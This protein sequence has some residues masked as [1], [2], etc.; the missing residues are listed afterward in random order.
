MC[1]GFAVFS[2]S[3]LGIFSVTS[4]AAWFIS[5]SQWNCDS[6]HI[7]STRSNE[8][9]LKCLLTFLQTYLS[10][11]HTNEHISQRNQVSYK[12]YLALTYYSIKLST[13][14]GNLLRAFLHRN[15]LPASERARL[16]WAH[17][18]TPGQQWTHIYEHFVLLSGCVWNLILKIINMHLSVWGVPYYELVPVFCD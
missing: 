1:Y 10:K 6:A 2:L 14:Q 15:T 12:R 3:D 11:S 17:S 9:E 4:A 13:S 8:K 5:S 7:T 18:Q 16:S